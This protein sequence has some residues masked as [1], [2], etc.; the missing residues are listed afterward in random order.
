MTGKVGLDFG[1]SNTVVAVWNGFEGEAYHLP[2]YGRF[3][4]PDPHLSPTPNIPSLIHYDAQRQW[5]GNQVLQQNLYKSPR[6]FR[7][8][9]RYI[10]Q[11]SQR[12]LQ[13]NGRTISAADAG[14]DF[15][16]AVLIALRTELELDPETEIACCT[17]IEAF[18]HYENWLLDTVR[19]TG[20]R[21]YPPY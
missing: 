13:L 19:A 11:R 18:E 20:F 15:L 1:T 9:K 17:P 3:Y 8:M 6:T 12:A 10:A 7:W 4:A 14:R 5:I 21:A 16:T 2:D